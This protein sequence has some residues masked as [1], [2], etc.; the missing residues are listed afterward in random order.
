MSLIQAA[1]GSAQLQRRDE[2]VARRRERVACHAEEQA[3]VD[4]LSLNYAGPDAANTRWMVT[5]VLAANASLP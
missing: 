5:A 2:L 4:S 3:G 1:L